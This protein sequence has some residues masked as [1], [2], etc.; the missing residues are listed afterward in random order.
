M[1]ILYAVILT[2]ESLTIWY[3]NFMMSSSSYPAAPALWNH[4]GPT[5]PWSSIKFFPL[6]FFKHKVTIAD[7]SRHAHVPEWLSWERALGSRALLVRSLHEVLPLPKLARIGSGLAS[8]YLLPAEVSPWTV[9]RTWRGTWPCWACR[10]PRLTPPPS[11]W[12]Q[13]GSQTLA[14]Q[15]QTPAGCFWQRPLRSEHQ[16]R[17]GDNTPASVAI[18]SLPPSERRS[19]VSEGT[20]ISLG[21]SYRVYAAPKVKVSYKSCHYKCWLCRKCDLQAI[22]LNWI[23]M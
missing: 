12:S 9:R 16:S 5:K 4:Q 21:Q 18:C 1:D 23:L 11:P 10:A 7:R 22:S 6:S 17:W 13:G 14:Q 19:A 3:M 15:R 8:A 2:R 20:G